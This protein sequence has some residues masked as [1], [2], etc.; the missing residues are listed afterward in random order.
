MSGPEDERFVDFSAIARVYVDTDSMTKEEVEGVCF[1]YIP[2][3]E[4][5]KT[6][7]PDVMYLKIHTGMKVQLADTKI[8]MLFTHEDIIAE[9]MSGSTTNA[10]HKCKS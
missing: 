2:Y 1:N 3:D 5:I 9:Y 7:N 6:Y 4:A 10:N 8:E